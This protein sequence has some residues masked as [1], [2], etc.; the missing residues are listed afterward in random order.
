[1]E[2]VFLSRF[3]GKERKEGRK[4][5]EFS[6]LRSAIAST[7]H[8]ESLILEGTAKFLHLINSWFLNFSIYLDLTE[9]QIA[10]KYTHKQPSS[11]KNATLPFKKTHHV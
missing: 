8:L 9:G 7:S 2:F 6:I 4:E 1:M 3:W 5:V 10:S 11:Q